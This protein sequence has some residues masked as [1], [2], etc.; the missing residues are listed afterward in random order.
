MRN[1]STGF[2]G[3][4]EYDSGINNSSPHLEKPTTGVPHAND[5]TA[6][7]PNVSRKRDGIKSILAWRYREANFHWSTLP[8]YITFPGYRSTRSRIDA[9]YGQS[10]HICQIIFHFNVSLL[11]E[12]WIES[13]SISTH[14]SSTRREAKRIWILFS[15]S[16]LT[17][18][19]RKKKSDYKK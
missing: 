17:I 19:V 13:I 4:R 9:S 11:R 16:M 8:W 2:S 14:F 15:W 10:E 12:L 6:V 3:S 5:S 1:D 7:S 18:K